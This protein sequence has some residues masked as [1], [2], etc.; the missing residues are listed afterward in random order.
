MDTIK[1]HVFPIFKTKS[2]SKYNATIRFGSGCVTKPGYQKE[3]LLNSI[4]KLSLGSQYTFAPAQK[5]YRIGLLFT[6]KNG[7][8]GAISG[9]E[10][11]CAAPISKVECFISD[12]FCATLW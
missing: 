11:S 7:D 1:P 3:R 10:R 12:R 2:A 4:S 9:T 5:S 6:N 8:F